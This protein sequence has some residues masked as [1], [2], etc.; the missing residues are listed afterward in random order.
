MCYHVRISLKKL[1]FFS[2]KTIRNIMYKITSKANLEH[3]YTVHNY[4]S[5]YNN[6]LIVY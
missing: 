5:Y 2:I 1:Y 3:R 4:S 6:I